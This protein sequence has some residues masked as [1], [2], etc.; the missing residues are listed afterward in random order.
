M[1]NKRLAL[2]IG[3]IVAIIVIVIFGVRI[4]TSENNPKENITK[5]TMAENVPSNNIVENKTT[6]NNNVMNIE[7]EEMEPIVKQK[8]DIEMD[9]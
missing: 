3:V 2:W 4:M 6:Q 1:K 5:N 7:I 8:D 9:W